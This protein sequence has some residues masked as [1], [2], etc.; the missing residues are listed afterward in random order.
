MNRK[1]LFVSGEPNSSRRI[2]RLISGQRKGH[3]HNILIHCHK[4]NYVNVYKKW[5]ASLFVYNIHK[6][7]LFNGLIIYRHEYFIN[8]NTT[9]QEVY[10]A[11]TQT[12]CTMGYQAK[13]MVFIYRSVLSPRIVHIILP[14]NSFFGSC[15]L[16]LSCNAA[17][18]TRAAKKTKIFSWP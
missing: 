18:P 14:I 8:Y 4:Y 15:R 13:I 12:V 11:T 17:F 10:Y 7:T 5:T 16:G 3:N 6:C 2:L 9:K 1:N